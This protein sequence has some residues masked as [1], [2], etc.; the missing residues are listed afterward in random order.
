MFSLEGV[1]ALYIHSLF[2]SNNA[3]DLYQTTNH[4]RSLNRGKIT[5]NDLDAL[6][7]K[8]NNLIYLT[9]LRT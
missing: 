4:N 5:N 3:Y 7:K 9:T 8:V 2:G 6:N 1:P